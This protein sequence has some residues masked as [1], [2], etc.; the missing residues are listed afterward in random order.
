MRSSLVVLLD[1]NYESVIGRVNIDKRPLLRD[2]P[3]GW[4]SI[5][6]ERIPI[7]KSLADLTIFTGNRPIR[8]LLEELQSKV[9]GHEL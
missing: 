7:Y 8:D 1:T 9:K 4:S 5:Y 6:E 3:G 2:D